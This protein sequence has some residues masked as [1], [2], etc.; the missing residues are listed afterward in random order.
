MLI[1]GVGLHGHQEAMGVASL[2]G[3][4]LPALPSQGVVDVLLDVP[5]V[6]RGDFVAVNFFWTAAALTLLSS[7]AMV[8]RPGQVHVMLDNPRPGPLEAQTVDAVVLWIRPT[9]SSTP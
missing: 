6:A 4:A 1:C 3:V 9:A 7:P 5:G 2:T 8:L